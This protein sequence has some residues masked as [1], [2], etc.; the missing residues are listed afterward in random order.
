MLQSSIVRRRLVGGRE[1]RGRRRRRRVRIVNGRKRRI[2]PWYVIRR[3]TL[4]LECAYQ[5]SSVH[6]SILKELS[7]P[8]RKKSRNSG[9]R[10]RSLFRRGYRKTEKQVIRNRKD[11]WALLF[12]ASAA[13]V[14]SQELCSA[15]TG[16]SQVRRTVAPQ[17]GVWMRESLW[18]VYLL[19]YSCNVILLSP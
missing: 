1:N 12:R 18:R 14:V 11:E 4:S 9:K 7:S 2:E 10:P 19:L 15:R 8:K 17:C 16:C 3:L 13:I 5:R 6:S